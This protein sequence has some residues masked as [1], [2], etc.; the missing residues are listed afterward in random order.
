M[1]SRFDECV[2][3]ELIN[4]TARVGSQVNVLVYTGERPILNTLGR[5][6]MGLS[7]L[8]SYAY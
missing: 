7:R 3:A 1:T 4:S 5:V 6:L 8:L 2:K